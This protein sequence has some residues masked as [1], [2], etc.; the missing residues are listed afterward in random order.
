MLVAA[1][2][3]VVVCGLLHVA[4]GGSVRLSAAEIW[5]QIARGPLPDGDANNVIVWQIRLPRALGTLLVGA[6][7]AGVG[8]AFQA[9]FRNP[10]AEPYTVGSSGGATVGGTLAVVL[11]LT[12]W[13]NMGIVAGA[14]LGA[15]AATVLVVTLG[16]T[17]PQLLLAGVVVST[18][19]ASLTTVLLLATGHDTNQVMRWLLGSTSAMLWPQVAVLVSGVAVGLFVFMALGRALNAMASSESA[20]TLGVDVV[21]VGRT[22]LGVG[23]VTTACAVGTVGLIGFVGLVAPLMARRTI[24]ADARRVVPLAACFGAVLLLLADLAAQLVVPGREMPVGAV[25]A[26]LGAPV[27]LSLLRS[28]RA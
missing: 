27:F 7:L 16:R 9:L 3:G 20:E 13:M 24:G 2:I 19:T 15:S 18:L 26:V 25:T 4:F 10:L 14:V 21:R 17:R 1:L 8:A 11:S 5:G 22:V 28:P 23:A 6:A 12:G